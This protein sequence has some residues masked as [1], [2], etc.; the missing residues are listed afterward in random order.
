MRAVKIIRT[1]EY[2]ALISSV[3]PIDEAV[4]DY[5]GFAKKKPLPPSVKILEVIDLPGEEAESIDWVDSRESE[6][7]NS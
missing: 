6:D 1:D 2:W 4:K 3:K 5:H 7:E